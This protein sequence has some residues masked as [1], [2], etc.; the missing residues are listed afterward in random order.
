[1][2]VTAAQLTLEAQ[3]LPVSLLVSALG[4]LPESPPFWEDDSFSAP[5]MQ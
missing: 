5:T 2:G 4:L 3:R 1:M